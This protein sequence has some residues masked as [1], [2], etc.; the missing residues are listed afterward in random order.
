[1]ALYTAKN[2]L[3]GL[4]VLTRSTAGALNS[5]SGAALGKIRQAITGVNPRHPTEVQAAQ[6]GSVVRKEIANAERTRRRNAQR[7][8]AYLEDQGYGPDSTFPISSADGVRH[9]PTSMICQAYAQA[10]VDEQC[11]T[12]KEMA[13]AVERGD[14]G[15]YLTGL[16]GEIVTSGRA[17]EI[18]AHPHG[19]PLDPAADDHD[20]PVCCAGCDC[21]SG[22][23]PG[24][25]TG[26][27]CREYDGT[28]LAGSAAPS[29]P[30][31]SPVSLYIDG[32]GNLVKADSPHSRSATYRTE[33]GK[34]VRRVVRGTLRPATVPEVLAAGHASGVCQ[35]CG[36]ALTSAT[37][38]T[39]GIGATCLARMGA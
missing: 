32:E 23:G 16:A 13:G 39:R 35:V 7:F 30:G 29:A 9:V 15:G 26:T 28:P 2:A 22:C 1:M 24:C 8:A 6:L 3:V 5:L 17:D 12:S 36:R 14:L 25:P 19:I 33:D 10:P 21:G 34:P 27:V 18:E 38:R 37:A 11:D 4:G 20:G 31:V